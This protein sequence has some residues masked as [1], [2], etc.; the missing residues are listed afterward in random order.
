MLQNI[1]DSSLPSPP[2]S[3]IIGESI[4]IDAPKAVNATLRTVSK[5]SASFTTRLKGLCTWHWRGGARNSASLKAQLA[6]RARV[7]RRPA[8]KM[9]LAGQRAKIESAK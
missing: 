8:A 7:G 4:A 6:I 2:A 1:A 3:N 5:A 9:V